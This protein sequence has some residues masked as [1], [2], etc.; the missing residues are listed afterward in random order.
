MRKMLVI[1]ADQEK[2]GSLPRPHTLKPSHEHQL[3]T[4]APQDVA[5]V[6]ATP[7]EA[8]EHYRDAEIIAAFPMRMPSL[9]EVPHAKWLHSFSAG[10]DKILTPAVAESDMFLTNSSGIHAVPIA[11]HI[12]G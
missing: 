4:A 10:V 1:A 7:D 8:K 12:V 9:S 5:I 6:V 2:R 11:E 3:H